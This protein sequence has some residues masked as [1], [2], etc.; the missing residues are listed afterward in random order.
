MSNSAGDARRT[1]VKV[2]LH[3]AWRGFAGGAKEVRIEAATL[4]DA[5]EG[6]STTH[7]SLRERMNTADFEHT[8]R[9]S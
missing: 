6:L 7:P 8:S 5:L 4:R 2:L 9:C 1:E 3:G